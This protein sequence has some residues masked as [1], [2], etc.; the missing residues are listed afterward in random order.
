M[1]RCPKC[2]YVGP[3]VIEHELTV[4]E[5]SKRSDEAEDEGEES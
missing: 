3:V 4:P 1:Y 5:E 2:E